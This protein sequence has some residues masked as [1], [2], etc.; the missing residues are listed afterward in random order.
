MQRREMS[1]ALVYVSPSLP[2]SGRPLFDPSDDL[3]A[4]GKEFALDIRKGLFSLRNDVEKERVVRGS[5]EYSQ[6]YFSGYIHI[7][8][9]ISKPLFVCYTSLDVEVS[10]LLYT[11]G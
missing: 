5:T 2:G 11:N 9:T 6:I 1:R 8:A 4:F 10:M 7:M 3:S